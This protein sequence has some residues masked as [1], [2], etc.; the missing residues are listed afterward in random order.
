[1][2]KEEAIAI[3]YRT[4]KP[5]QLVSGVAHSKKA[6][7]KK[8]SKADSQAFTSKTNVKTK[9][10]KGRGNSNMGVAH[11]Q[12]STSKK[13]SKAD[14]QASTSKK[15]AKTKDGKGRG[16]SNMVQN[17][18]VSDVQQSQASSRGALTV[19]NEQFGVLVLRF[20]QGRPVSRV[21]DRGSNNG[22]VESS[23]V[24]IGDI[25]Y[26]PRKVM[27]FVKAGRHSFDSENKIKFECTTC[28][29]SFHSYQALGGHRERHKRTKGYENI[30]I[31]IEHMQNQATDSK[32]TNTKNSS[33]DSTIDEFGEKFETSSVSKKQK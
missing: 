7:S 2:V 23:T 1:M 26:K 33:N 25:G 9:G 24:V 31:E 14:S 5:Q 3:W 18:Q 6:T 20:Q 29:K 4:H 30:S 32:L 15:N 17:S 22:A 19:F 21:I 11:S 10:S 27:I 28:K 8:R 13:R 16:N 12:K